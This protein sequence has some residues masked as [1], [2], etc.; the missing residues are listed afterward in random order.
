[1]AEF[2]EPNLLAMSEAELFMELGR[3]AIGSVRADHPYDDNEL[4]DVGRSTFERWLREHR[5]RFCLDPKI[6]TLRAKMNGDETTDVTVV[7]DVIVSMKAALP[8][9]TLTVI[10]LRRGLDTLCPPSQH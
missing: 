4:E 7:L 10:V 8:V 6:Q 1:M 2:V 9:A 5:D 3:S